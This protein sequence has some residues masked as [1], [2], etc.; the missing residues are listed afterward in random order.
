VFLSINIS[1]SIL[2]LS[3]EEADAHCSQ[4]QP[5]L[6]NIDRDLERW[7]QDGIPR[8]LIERTLLQHTTRKSGQ[9]GFAAGFWK[10]RAYL[11]DPPN[12]TVTG[13]HALLLFVYMQNLVL[14]QKSFQ[15]PDVVR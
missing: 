8:E 14:L 6:S 11:L 1:S 7:K 3:K 2:P 9:K 12:L 13:H 10:G 15:I 4:F 5:L